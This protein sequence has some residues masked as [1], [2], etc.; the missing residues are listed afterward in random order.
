MIIQERNVFYFNKQYA[1]E[2]EEIFI[3]DFNDKLKNFEIFIKQI[4]NLKYLTI[5]CFHNTDIIDACQWEHLIT[6]FLPYLK[7]FK[8]RFRCFMFDNDK[9]IIIDKFKQ[10]QTDFWQKQHRWYTEYVK[11]QEIAFIY[12]IPFMLHTFELISNNINT[13]TNIN[14]FNKVTHLTLNMDIITENYRCYFSNVTSLTLMLTNPYGHLT[15]KPIEYLKT[16]VNLCN[17]KHLC[18][19]LMESHS[20]FLELLKETPQLS[21]MT[22]NA[23]SLNSIYSNRESWNYLKKIKRLCQNDIENIEFHWSDEKEKQFCEI[24]FNLEHLQCAISNK[25]EL[26]F[27]LNQLPK[28]STLEITWKCKSNPKVKFATFKWKAQK[29]NII[30]DTKYKLHNTYDDF[31]SI[32]GFYY[33]IN[34]FIWI[35]KNMN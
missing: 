3:G 11:A 19:P 28:L 6:F 23:S 25:Y 30:Y 18:I 24:F 21:S 29:L 35:G 26:L 27:L 5:S 16:I 4:P 34:V 31:E 20:V 2:L 10:F 9:N 15:I 7:I 8:F 12:T 13:I 33:V 1:L 17:V 14:T 32:D 22:T